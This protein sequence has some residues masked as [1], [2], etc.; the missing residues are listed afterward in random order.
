MQFFTL[1]V[2]Y[3]KDNNKGKLPIIENLLRSIYSYLISFILLKLVSF[4]KFYA[5]IFD[6]FALEIKNANALGKYFIKGLHIVKRKLFIFYIAIIFFSLFFLYYLTLFCYIYTT[7][8]MS[9]FIGAWVSLGI[10]FA[11]TFIYA[12]IFSILKVIALKCKIRS[13]YNLLLFIYYIY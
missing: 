8:Q 9:W 2:L 10:S 12:F 4:L 6:V 3:Q 13:L 1:I 7:I 5:P 11:V